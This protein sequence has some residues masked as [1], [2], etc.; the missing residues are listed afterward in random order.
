M[1]GN[2]SWRLS[3]LPHL[4]IYKQPPTPAN[5]PVPKEIPSNPPPATAQPLNLACLFGVSAH[6][7]IKIHQHQKQHQI[8]KY[9]ENGENG[10]MTPATL[11]IARLTPFSPILG[12]W[13]SG[14]SVGKMGGFWCLWVNFG[15]IAGNYRLL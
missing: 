2:G 3:H 7:H 14:E 12:K 10:K 5:C 13:E 1:A 15:A 9:W 4:A 6:N 8:I 11:D